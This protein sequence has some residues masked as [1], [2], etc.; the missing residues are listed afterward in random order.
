MGRKPQKRTLLTRA[1]I[2]DAARTIAEAKGGLEA[3]TAEAIAK[4]ADV[5]KGTVFAHFGDMDGLL[6]HLL[7]DNLAALRARA[8]SDTDVGAI[9]TPDPVEALMDRMMS[10]IALITE[11]Q[12]MLRV[13]MENIGVTKGHC[14]PEFVAHLDALDASLASLLGHWQDS[15]TIQPELRRDRTPAEMVDGLI[16]FMIH[17]AILFRSHQIDDLE[18]IRK[19]L[20]RHVE[21]FLLSQ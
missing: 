5:A 14:A 18:I 8:E 7:L 12:T 9:L 15:K 4:E 3:L 6:S 17:G 19:R 2:I 13:F 1:K 11:S 10:L 16:A 20:K 21:A